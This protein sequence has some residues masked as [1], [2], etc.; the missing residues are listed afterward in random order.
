MSTPSLLSHALLVHEAPT[1]YKVATSSENVNFWQSGIDGEHDCLNR[2]YTRDFVDHASG[3]KLLPC[4]YIFKAKENKPKVRLVAL[5]CRQI[6]GID[7]KETYAPVVTL[8]TV[9]TILAVVAHLDLELEQMDVVT[10]FLNGDLKEDIFMAVPEG[11]KSKTTSGKLCK[12][13]KSLYGL[14]Q[15][16]RQWYAKMHQFLV[17]ELE[18]K[19]SPNDPCLYTRHKSSSILLIALYV[20]DI[21]IAGSM[22]AEV[23]SIKNRLAARFEMKDLGIA[24]VILGIQIRETE[25]TENSS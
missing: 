12:L 8:T 11:L 16:T 17:N 20:D 21:L 22:K 2:N 19:S 9:R 3:V 23:Q 1:S 24:R 15:S 25:L 13:R 14:K 4:K 18:F 10:A 6:Y 7:Y 5:S